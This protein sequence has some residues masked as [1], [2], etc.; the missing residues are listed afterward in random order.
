MCRVLMMNKQGEREIEKSFGLTKYLKFLED[1]FGGD[2]NGFALL[3]SNKIIKFEKGRKLDIRD[4]SKYIKENDYD[5]CLFHTRFASVGIKSDKNCHPFIIGDMM[6][7]M[8]GTERSVSF[9]S[10]VKDITD[11]EAILETISKYN[12]GLG[13]LK[14]FSSIFMGFYKGKPF[15]VA[16][17]T[18]NIRVFKKEKSKALVFAS[19]FPSKMMKNIYAP[20]DNFTW[21]ENKLPDCLVKYINVQTSPILL[22]DYI[23]HDDL[24]AQCYIEALEK[25]GGTINGVSI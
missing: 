17:N 11:T 22:D 21:F 5:W 15:V 12:L 14:K 9:L 24:Y 20:T 4:I 16:D 7:A 13:A 23:Y 25:E 3:K 2:G 6:L 18:Y 8:N 19:K 1:D 10:E